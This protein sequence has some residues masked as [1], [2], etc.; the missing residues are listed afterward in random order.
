MIFA[1]E[2]L[3]IFY[4]AV[5]VSKPVSRGGGGGGGGGSPEKRTYGVSR[6]QNRYVRL[7]LGKMCR[8]VWYFHKKSN[9][10]IQTLSTPGTIV[11]ID[12]DHD[13]VVTYPS[14]NRWDT[15]WYTVILNGLYQ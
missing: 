10:S 2:N 14:G 3:F 12:E 1:E 9:S 11:G 7:P 13:I 5:D 8:E 4:T 6:G 15:C